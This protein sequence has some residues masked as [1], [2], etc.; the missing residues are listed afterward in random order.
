MISW[1]EIAKQT[2]IEF[3]SSAL[4]VSITCQ[5]NKNGSTIGICTLG[6]LPK[7]NS[8]LLIIACFVDDFIY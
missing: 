7:F 6:I 4:K 8:E 2:E 1:S 3:I 5:V